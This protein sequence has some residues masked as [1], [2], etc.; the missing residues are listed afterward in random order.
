VPPAIARLIAF[1]VAYIPVFARVTRASA[2]TVH[3]SGYVLAAGAYGGRPLA[4]I[5]QERRPA[6]SSHQGMFAG[7]R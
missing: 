2:L 6:P 5:R 3:S 4:I 7:G 1:G